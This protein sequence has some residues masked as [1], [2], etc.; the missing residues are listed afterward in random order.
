MKPEESDYLKKIYRK[1][2]CTWNQ[3]DERI[4][5]FKSSQKEFKNMKK[6]LRKKDTIIKNQEKIVVKLKRQIETLKIKNAKVKIAKKNTQLGKDIFLK[7]IRKDQM[8]KLKPLINRIQNNMEFNLEYTKADIKREFFIHSY[9]KIDAC[10]DYLIKNEIV[11]K[12]VKDG[13]VRYVRNG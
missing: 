9:L 5:D 7:D 11:S 1:N 3:A 2:G 12:S 13:F 4:D 8:Q 10:M 6:D